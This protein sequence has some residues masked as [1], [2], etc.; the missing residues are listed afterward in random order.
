MKRQ[1]EQHRQKDRL[2]FSVLACAV[3]LV[4]LTV[5]GI[6][7]QVFGK[8][9]VK[10]SEWFAKSDKQIEQIVDDTADNLTDNA[11]NTVDN[12]GGETETE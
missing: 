12:A 11:D 7:L 5:V 6:G 8:G 1:F 2:R 3:F 4:V 9:K 10:P